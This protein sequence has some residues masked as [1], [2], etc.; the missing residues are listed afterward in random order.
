MNEKTQ[1]ETENRT[2]DAEFGTDLQAYLMKAAEVG[3][4]KDLN[5]TASGVKLSKTEK[6]VHYDL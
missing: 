6:L 3:V 4:P 2:T 1:I 5:E